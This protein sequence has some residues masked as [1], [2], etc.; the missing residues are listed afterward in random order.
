MAVNPLLTLMLNLVDVSSS[1]HSSV[2]DEVLR[3]IE[4]QCVF[5]AL[6]SDLAEVEPAQKDLIDG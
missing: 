2:K 6:I 3:V 1:T 4:S 5:E